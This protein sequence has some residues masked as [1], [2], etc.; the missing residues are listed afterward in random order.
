MEADEIRATLE[1]GGLTQYEADVYLALLELGG[2]TATQIAEA[3]DVPQA[4]I[5]D[6]LRGL[7]GEGY[8]DT[9]E[10]GTLRAQARDPAEVVEHLKAYADEFRSA[11]DAIN[12]R[13]ER[14]ALDQQTVSVVKRFDTVFGHALDRIAEA[15]NEIQVAITPER[16]PRLE[17]ALRDAVDRDVVVKLTLMPTAD[18]DRSEVSASDISSVFDVSLEGLATEVRYCRIPNPFVLLTDRTKV[19]F[20]PFRATFQTN[21]YGVLVDDYALSTVFDWYFQ[22]ALWEYWTPIYS[23]R[24]DALPRVYTSIRECLRDIAPRVEEGHRVVLTV[25][26]KDRQTGDPEELIGVVTGT[27]L[28]TTADEGAPP[29]Q[30]FLEEATV[31]LEVDGERYEVGGWG[32]VFEE[33]EAR[34][35]VVE[36]I[37]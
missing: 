20:A 16:L 8:V 22:T 14:P 37:E 29:L 3:A 15:D 24:D 19:C 21:E 13:W 1:R 17:Q 7:E 36:A 34:R 12:E 9:Y 5:Y 35:F 25:E 2:G 33:I 27:Q 4:R 30:Q 31:E 18:T 6:V 11:A 23:T 32:A 28:T 10:E 26:G